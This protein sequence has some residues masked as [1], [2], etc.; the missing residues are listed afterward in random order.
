MPKAAPAL[1][2]LS[3]RHSRLQVGEAFAEQELRAL[4]HQPW[5]PALCRALRRTIALRSCCIR[6]I[7][8]CLRRHRWTFIHTA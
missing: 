8:E 2:H 7:L 6:T 5:A 4:L 3:L 1:L